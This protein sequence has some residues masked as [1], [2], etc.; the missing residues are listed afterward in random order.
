MKQ[1]KTSYYNE[2][3]LILKNNYIRELERNFNRS[4]VAD[5]INAIK[6]MDNDLFVLKFEAHGDGM[7]MVYPPEKGTPEYQAHVEELRNYWLNTNALQLTPAI[8]ATLLN[9]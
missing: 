5:V 4:D 6:S 3:D 2:K 9:T 7:E 8:L 1:S